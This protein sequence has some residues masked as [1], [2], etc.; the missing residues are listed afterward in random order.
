MQNTKLHLYAASVIACA[1]TAFN[2]SSVEATNP[3]EHPAPP[4]YRPW[5]LG[6]EGGTTGFGAAGSWRFSDHFGLRA[7]ADYLESS[8]SG[9]ELGN[10]SYDVKL[11][12]L[13]EPLTLD[14]Y[15]WKKHS[16]HVSVGLLFNQNQL[17][18]SATDSGAIIPPASLGTLNL[19][20]EQ[21]PV[22][23]YLSI[24]G[25]FFYFD[26]AH[27]WAL[28]GELGVAYTGDATVSWTRSG[29]STPCLTPPC[30]ASRAISRTMP[31]SSAGTR[32]SSSW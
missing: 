27:H 21:Q 24:A 10:L 15:P 5:T 8:Q 4:D 11:R 1:V 18:G 28:G 3:A 32:W 9:T 22:N 31:I 23:P 17:T 12:L 25:N 2:A 16:F 26:H 14:L 30:A 19:N 6:I 29:P 7:G 13:S 20:I